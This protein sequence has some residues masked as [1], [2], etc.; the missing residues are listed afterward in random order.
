MLAESILMID[1][2]KGFPMNRLLRLRRE[3]G[4]GLTSLVGLVFR[5]ALILCVFAWTAC[6]PN[7]K[8]TTNTHTLTQT[9]SSI[10]TVDG[11]ATLENSS[12]DLMMPKSPDS[13]VAYPSG[14]PIPDPVQENIILLQA[15]YPQEKIVERIRSS[16]TAYNLE[17]EDI[18][19]LSDIG[20]PTE[21]IAEMVRADRSAYV[22]DPEVETAL[23]VM[24]DPQDEYAQDL[25]VNANLGSS[26]GTPT[27]QLVQN[28]NV[29]S[30]T[31]PADLLP[32]QTLSDSFANQT[33]PDPAVGA[34]VVAQ[35][36]ESSAAS[37]TPY[38]ISG[39][40]TQFY[41]PLS[42]YGDW[43]YVNDI[44]WCWRPT[45]ASVHSDWAP[46]R[47]QG[48]WVYSD[49]GWYWD[50]Y[51][52]WGWAPFHYGRWARHA[53]YGWV[54]RP[55]SNWGPAWV[56]W[57]YNNSYCG[58]APLPP[59]SLYVSGVGFS[60]FGSRVGASFGF[61]IGYYDY[62][63][64]PFNRFHGYRVDRYAVYGG[65]GRD[66]YS[67]STVIN[68]YVVGDN[69]TIV[70]QGVALK[71][72]ESRIG[73][74]IQTT[75]VR[76]QEVPGDSARIAA[77]QTRGTDGIVAHRVPVNQVS[78]PIPIA[79]AGN[80][81]LGSRTSSDVGA[82][83]ITRSSTGTAS[84]G[85]VAISS[86]PTSLSSRPGGTAES[87]GDPIAMRPT[88]NSDS[89]L[90]APRTAEVRS[91]VNAPR[92]VRDS[93][94][95]SNSGNAS[96]EVDRSGMVT[97]PTR[98][99]NTPSIAA[100]PTPTPAPTPPST[101][102]RATSTVRS[103]G[104]VTSQQPTS[105]T[106]QP[107]ATEISRPSVS[108]NSPR[109]IATPNSPTGVQVPRPAPAPAPAPRVSTPTPRPS[110]QTR[111]GGFQSSPAPAVNQR[112]PRQTVSRTPAPIS[113]SPGASNFNPRPTPTP[114]PRTSVS[115]RAT[116][117]PTPAPTPTPG[118]SVRTRSGG[119]QSSPSPRSVSPSA[120]APRAPGAGQ[121]ISPRAGSA[122]TPTPTPSRSAS[123]PGGASVTVK[124]GGFQS[125][126]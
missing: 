28:V 53:S 120:P 44:G 58:W 42:P 90:K 36:E 6:Q 73:K 59:H 102:S 124:S 49:Y 35:S 104:F 57:R 86:S 63:F 68:N 16:Q 94:V 30:T 109:E 74:T 112:S 110:V 34:V 12:N 32:E 14:K 122:P 15:Q 99:S 4:G 1:S 64:L 31:A 48:R 75:P 105:I 84:S 45:V 103:G 101:A 56:T 27:E 9:P 17:A 125:P 93:S 66:I 65:R 67:N 91:S 13:L 23:G 113:N 98:R 18:L 89:S 54:W 106:R 116:P 5:S 22:I 71:T 11:Q 126:R 87:T 79:T 92:T 70:N 69:N 121:S 7:A 78:K 115:P 97:V 117:T 72:V 38:E 118:P 80:N 55:G 96:R 50:S 3:I 43:V 60:Y 41:E 76:I 111:S 119:F 51:Y 40:A 21:V 108:R 62:T 107:S 24:Q 88:V 29:T 61:G 10:Q 82:R 85:P 81:I 52:T 123:N 46:Y 2:L 19:Y 33:S 8:R 26:V 25:P 100:R 83:N 20:T 95:Q 39:P 37:E 77:S 47:S 114:A